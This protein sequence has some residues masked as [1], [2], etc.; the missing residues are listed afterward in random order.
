MPSLFQASAPCVPSFAEKNKVP[1]TFVSS[2]GDEPEAPGW[3]SLTSTVPTAVPLLFQELGAMRAIIG[4]KEKDVA[5]IRHIRGRRA[6]SEAA[7][8]E[9]CRRDRQ[10]T[11]LFQDLELPLTRRR[12]ECAQ[13]A[14]L[15]RL[16]RL[17][18][19]CMCW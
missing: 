5:D 13:R 8:G 6:G 1:F 12:T 11:T 10:Q 9:H 15:S 7:I 14:D 16:D 3:I 19:R 18:P 17:R 2:A 4:G